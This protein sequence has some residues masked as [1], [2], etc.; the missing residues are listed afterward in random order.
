VLRLIGYLLILAGIP[1]LFF[2]CFPGLICM[3]L[4][5]IVVLLSKR[6]S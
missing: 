1:L 5:A 3:G 4:G 2:A 6:K